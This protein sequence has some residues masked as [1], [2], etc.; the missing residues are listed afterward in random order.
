[1]LQY[2]ALPTNYPDPDPDPDPDV[3]RK[4]RLLKLRT[5]GDYARVRELVCI[6][7]DPSSVRN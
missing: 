1:M 3:G 5:D 2:G 7:L 6:D 4:H